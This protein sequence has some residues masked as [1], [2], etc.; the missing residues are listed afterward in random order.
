MPEKLP[1]G[2]IK[3]TLGNIA[4]PSRERALPAEVPDMPYV[5]LEHI[6]PHTMRLLGRDTARDVRSSSVRF[7]KGDVLYGKMRPY[8]NKVWVAE[9]DGLCSAEFLV[10]PKRDGLHSEFLA[11]RLN[12]E[13]FVTFANGQVSGERPRVDFRKL[14]NFPI[15]LPPAGE[16]ERIVTKLSAAVSKVN[17]AEAAARRA[18]QRLQRY[19]VAIVDAALI[20]ELTRGWR[21]SGRKNEK[22]NL[23]TGEE[24]LL[25]LLTARRQLWEETELKRLSALKK[26]P[27][28][29]EWKSRYHEP[30]PPKTDNLPDLPE[31]WA[32]AATEQLG[33]VV[34]GSTPTKSRPEFFGG[35]VPFYK[36][37]D[38]DAGFYVASSHDSLTKAGIEHAR[39]IPEN[40]IL[41]TCIG[42]TIGKTGFARKAGA[43]NQ[44]INALVPAVAPMAE[45]LFIV[46][47]GS[48][49]QG[50]IRSS[51]SATTL[52][53]L[54]KSKFER[55][56]IPLPPL[57]EQNE[58][59]REIDRR[60]LAADRLLAKL[61]PQVV[62]ARATR[63]SLLREA[64]AGRLVPQ[65]PKD[66][67]ASVLLRRI[68]AA[69][70]AESQKPK[71]RPM[72]KSKSETRASIRR[73]LLLVLKEN[74]PMTPE[75]LFQSSG[76]SQE[77]VDEFFAELRELTSP[78][79]K[80][81]EE[82]KAG[83]KIILKA[84]P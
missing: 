1:K 74:G 15:L 61:E 65:D 29:E 70:E 80:L 54:N 52:P 73:N 72:A 79:A 49:M 8:L 34:T 64:F 81:L 36:P 11:A 55:L 44:Q 57:A 32:W 43:T 17:R 9:F 20:G 76:H 63:Q 5:G 13:D 62:R 2:W 60:L 28:N 46:F 26:V 30:A 12:A 77:S 33:E 18:N 19:R 6:E 42:A 51:A 31:G 37:S 4:E 83:S 58:I 23:E 69:R 75:E 66:E 71:A 38:L 24:L 35:N 3:T 47:T 53:I 16:Q 21:E 25:R 41:V 84:V 40:S 10:F 22:D 48:R 82:R 39:V 67:P 14:L 56:P 50:K 68:R 7:S 27:K 45:F 59:V 78:P